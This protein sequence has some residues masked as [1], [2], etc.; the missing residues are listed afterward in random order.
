LVLPLSLALAAVTG[1]AQEF[2]QATGVKVGEVTDSSAI[3]WMR[4][5]AKA[6]RNADGILRKGPLMLAPAKDADPSK[7]EG[8]CP[9][10]AGRVR[11]RYGLREDLSNAQETAWADVSAKTDFTHQ[12]RLTGLKPGAVYHYAAET[13][14]P[15]GEPKHAALRGRFETAPRSDVFTDMT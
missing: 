8:A 1:S 4:V 14:G 13:S 11:L 7:F 5:T 6:G 10:A 15:K 12:F 9:G 2:R 3:V